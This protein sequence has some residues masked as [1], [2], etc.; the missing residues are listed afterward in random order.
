MILMNARVRLPSV[1]I[2]YNTNIIMEFDINYWADVTYISR[3]FAGREDIT[4]RHI[5]TEKLNSIPYIKYQNDAKLVDTMHLSVLTAGKIVQDTCFEKIE[6][7]RLKPNQYVKNLRLNIPDDKCNELTIELGGQRYE[8][9]YGKF[10][11]VLRTIY[12]ITDPTVV[13]ADLTYR[14]IIPFLDNYTTLFSIE[15]AASVHDNGGALVLTFDVYEINGDFTNLMTESPIFQIVYSGPDNID[16]GRVRLG[17]VHPCYYM[18]IR[19]S[20]GKHITHLRIS[21]EQH[22]LEYTKEQLQGVLLGDTYIIPFTPSMQWADIR[23]YGIDTS[24]IGS[25]CVYID[26]LD[27][28]EE[29]DVYGVMANIVRHAGGM[30]GIAY[31][32]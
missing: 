29:V 5:T 19:V 17:F 7:P 12:G 16:K 4:L 8:R 18:A 24:R 27:E 20:S 32:K 22:D 2:M 13:P 11:K 26:G 25:I 1:Y 3:E 9:I 28:G 31:S 10:F 23:R 6:L 14:L 30:L 21:F 15:Y